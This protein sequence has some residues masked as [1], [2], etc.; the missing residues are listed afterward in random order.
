M[1]L[2]KNKQTKNLLNLAF[3]FL[4]S[5][6]SQLWAHELVSEDSTYQTVKMLNPKK[7]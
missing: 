1:T 7:V 2:L 3:N 5:L 4:T 6:L